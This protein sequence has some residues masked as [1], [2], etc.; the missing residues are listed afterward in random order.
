[1][2]FKNRQEAGQKLALALKKFKNEKDALIL[3]L[4]RGGVVVAYEI[5]RD[6][7]LPLDLVVPRKIGAPIN[8]EYAIGAITETGE[9][10]FNQEAIS[11]LN[12]SK[13]YLDSKVAE[14]KK[15]A[16]RRLKIYR[17]DREPLNLTNK[18]VIIVDDGIATGLT[19]RAAI[20]SAKEKSAKKIIVAVPITAND[21]L[22]IIE[23]EADEVI[24]LDAPAF[25]GAVGEF[26]EEFAQT[27]DQEVIEL[28]EKSK[29]FGQEL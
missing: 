24:Y 6:L 2:V 23:K 4:P 9:G 14:E 12:I 29:N 28:M 11:S 20:K 21:S 26:Y 13:T 22:K 25:F 5:A 7:N 16:E 1:M 15:E 10:I 27:T 8:E 17:Q 18:T 19:M 3:A